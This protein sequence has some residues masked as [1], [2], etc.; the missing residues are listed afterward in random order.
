M[1]LRA[2]FPVLEKEREFGQ[3]CECLEKAL[4]ERR[5]HLRQ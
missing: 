5:V 1:R 3:E 2:E 4:R